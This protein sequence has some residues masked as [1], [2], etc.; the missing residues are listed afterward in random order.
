VRIKR[1]LKRL[2]R[3]CLVLAQ[4]YLSGAQNSN[5]LFARIGQNRIISELFNTNFKFR[6]ESRFFS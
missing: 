1:A 3:N 2:T 6:R 4:E 5:A